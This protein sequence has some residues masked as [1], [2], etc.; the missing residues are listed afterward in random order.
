MTSTQKLYIKLTRDEKDKLD[1]AVDVFEEILA[2][3]VYNKDNGHTPWQEGL[4]IYD[5]FWK[6]YHM[7]LNIDKDELI[8]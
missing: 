1:E 8:P 7:C 6:I 3:L 5:S 4:D 2:H